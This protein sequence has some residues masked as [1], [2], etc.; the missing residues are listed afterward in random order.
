MHQGVSGR[1]VGRLEL[2]G[3]GSQAAF[4]GPSESLA[5][6]QQRAVE[7]EA[8]VCLQAVGEALQHLQ[9]A[10]Q[11]CPHTP[12]PGKDS[13]GPAHPGVLRVV[14]KWGAPKKTNP[15]AGDMF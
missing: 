12:V 8:D 3:Q 5:V 6:L 14:A 4:A 10:R 7:V 9:R 2:H 11:R 15:K 13:H 1:R